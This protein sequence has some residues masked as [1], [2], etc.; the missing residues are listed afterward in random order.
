[1]Q[2]NF[3]QTVYE[4]MIGVL[5]QEYRVPGVSNEYEPG[6][7]CDLL[8]K[9]VY[10]AN[11]RLCQRLG[12]PC[13]DEDVETIISNMFDIQQIL[14]LRMYEYGVKFGAPD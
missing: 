12:I 8:Y 13:D 2:E 5:K 3:T 9:E 10:D 1:M 4:T 6:K 14:C 11:C 7:P